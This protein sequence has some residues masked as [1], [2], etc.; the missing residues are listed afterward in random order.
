[1]LPLIP[2][3]ALSFVSFIASAFVILRIVIPILPPHPLS[4]RVPPVS[5]PSYLSSSQTLI[6]VYSP[7]LVSPTSG[8]FLP[9]TRATSGSLHAISSPS[10]SFYGRHSMN[11]SMARPCTTSLLTPF[12]LFASGLPLPSGSLAS[13]WWHH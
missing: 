5:H 9:Q 8:H 2:T 7:N 12:Q 1:M 3:L 11:I 10:Q 6:C 13:S 4:R